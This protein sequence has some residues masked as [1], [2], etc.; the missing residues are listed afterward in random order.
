MVGNLFFATIG[1]VVG[2]LLFRMPDGLR[3]Y[4]AAG[5]T[6]LGIA[7]LC[8]LLV[9]RAAIAAILLVTPPTDVYTSSFVGLSYGLL[10]R[11]LVSFGLSRVRRKGNSEL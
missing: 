1:F 8:G 10:V 3:G 7:L 11:G 2:C 4:L 6:M 5:A 9:D